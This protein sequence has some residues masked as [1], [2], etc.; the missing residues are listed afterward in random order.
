MRRIAYRGWSSGTELD[1][2]VHSGTEVVGDRLRMAATTAIRVYTDPHRPGRTRS[3][4]QAS[5]T[6]P[7][8]TPG[9]AASELIPSW[10]ARTPEGT[11]LEVQVAAILDDST[12]T[13]W[14]VLGRWAETDDEILPA[15]V[16]GQGDDRAVVAFDILLAKAPRTISSYRLG[17]NLLRRPG[18]ASSPT[19]SL[20]GAMASHVPADAQVPRSASGGAEGLVIDVPRYSQQVHRG[21]YPQWDSGG[22]S[23]CSPTST[24]MVLAHWGR[25]PAPEEYAWVDPTLHDRFV[26]HAARHTF[27][28]NYRGAGNWSFNTAYAARYGVRAYV[29]RLRSLTEVEQFIRTGIPLVVSVSFD[30]HELDGAGYATAGHLLTVVGFD[31]DGNVIC[32][33]PASHGIAS[34]D[35]VRTTYDREQFENAWM[36]P[37]RGITYVIHPPEVP[38]PERPAEPNW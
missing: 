16:P 38:L 31:A 9:F 24:T 37:S 11:W 21:E 20:L 6:S 33:D 34:N 30:E 3:Y 28:Y 32:N 29:T 18:S 13:G 2:G 10:N 1:L 27:D 15:S 4:E 7:A 14:F 25:G 36:V 35:E 17:V 22:R 26:D 5:W 19:V 8:V 23:W 12:S